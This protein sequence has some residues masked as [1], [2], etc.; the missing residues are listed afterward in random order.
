M[1]LKCFTRDNAARQENYMQISKELSYVQSPYLLRV[2]YLPDEL[3]VAGSR[4]DQEEFPVL[5]MNWVEWQTLDSY[6]RSNINNPQ[7]LRRLSADFNRMA[8]WLLTQPFAHG[9]LKPDNIIVQPDGALVLVDYDGMYVPSMK[10]QNALETGSPNFRHPQRTAQWFDEYMDDFPLCL[11]ATSLYALYLNPDLLTEYDAKDAILFTE[12][13]LLNLPK[14]KL[15]SS[16]SALLG[17][18]GF[19]KLHSLLTLA[20][21]K[22]HIKGVCAPVVAGL[23]AKQDIYRLLYDKAMEQYLNSDDKSAAYLLLAQAA[24]PDRLNRKMQLFC[25]TAEEAEEEK[26]QI[27]RLT[28]LANAGRCL[29]TTYA[30]Q[31]LWQRLG[32]GKRL[33]ASR[34]LVHKSSLSRQPIGT[35]QTRLLLFQRLGSG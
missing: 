20:F 29:C 5:V 25:K 4:N 28:L 11:M 35:V 17:N 23:D 32:S 1:A 24:D 15:Y 7:R 12:K 9:D 21:A 26:S 3:F 8:L 22:V 33:H 13:D 18:P 10:G 16:L 27:K 6:L 30:R 34:P 19:A 31:L 2:R 14:S